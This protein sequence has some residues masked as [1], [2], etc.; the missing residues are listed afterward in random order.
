MNGH[1]LGNDRN[2]KL[3][4]ALAGVS[5]ELETFWSRFKDSSEKRNAIVHRRQHATKPE[6]EESLQAAT[7]LI[8]FLKQ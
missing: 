5:I 7:E 4:N 8:R 2:R 3:L 1:N 6:A